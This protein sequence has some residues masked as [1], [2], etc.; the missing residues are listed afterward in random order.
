[1]KYSLNEKNDTVV[2]AFEGD[3]DLK[4]SG[5]VRTVLLDCVSRGRAVLVDMSGVALIDSSGVAVL[6]EAFQNSR[7]KG[8]E[9]VLAE[10]GDSVLRVL[11]LARLETIF[12]IANSVSDG[13]REKA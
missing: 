7:K 11:K 12:T 9:F 10:I 6:L 13:L 1:M 4:S 8:K 3:I 2:V 5:E